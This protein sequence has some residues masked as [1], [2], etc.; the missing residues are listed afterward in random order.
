MYDWFLGEV[1]SVEKSN[2]NAVTPSTGESGGEEAKG[3]A[4]AVVSEAPNEPL[5]L[6]TFRHCFNKILLLKKN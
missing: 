1:R 6:L 5:T 2:T 4:D 3:G